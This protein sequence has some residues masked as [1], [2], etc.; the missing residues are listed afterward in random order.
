MRQANEAEQ[1]M[2]SEGLEVFIRWSGLRSKHIAQSLHDWLRNVLPLVRPWMSEEDIQKGARGAL[3]I[4]RKLE[5]VSVGVSCLTPENQHAPWIQFEAGALSKTLDN[6]RLERDS[7][8]N[9]A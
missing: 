1:P 9:L 4:A 8:A 3:D 6:S 5:K 2:Q 7:P